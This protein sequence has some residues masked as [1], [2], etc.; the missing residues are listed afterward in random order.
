MRNSFGFK[1]AAVVGLLGFVALGISAFAVR[2]SLWEQDRAAATDRIWN[3]GLQAGALR[4]AIE[5]AVVQATALYTAED[6]QEARTRLSG[7]QDALAAVEQVQVPFLAAMED[8][9][10]PDRRRRF[11]LFVKEFIAYQTDTAELGLTISPKAALIQATDESTVKNRERMI[12]EIGGLG[13]EVLARLNDQ[14]AAG[15]IEQRRAIV[16]LIVA[17]AVALALALAAAIWIAVSQIQKPLRRLKAAMQAL[18]ADRLD[19]TIPFTERQDAIGQ[20]AHAIAAFQAA[21]IERRTL[22]HDARARTARDLV[23]A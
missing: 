18:A 21:M 16:A 13:R 7:L 15:V 3:A 1:L 19:D 12:A 4:Q 5:H 8:Q 20:M 17:P 2:Q 10:P 23:R 9:L 11:D 14:R 22:D 6:T